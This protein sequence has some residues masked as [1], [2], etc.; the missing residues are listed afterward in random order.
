MFWNILKQLY[1]PSHEV[2]T[3]DIIP[4]LI[5]NNSLFVS[6]F[7]IIKSVLLLLCKWMFKAWCDIKLISLIFW[8]STYFNNSLK[9]S[10]T[11]ADAIQI[12]SLIITFFITPNFF[13]SLYTFSPILILSRSE[14]SSEIVIFESANI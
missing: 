11:P 4:F 7:A 8:V 2:S 5:S 14:S 10:K 3:F 12:F 9:S 1:E 6:I 13:K